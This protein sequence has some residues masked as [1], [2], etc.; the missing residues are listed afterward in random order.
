MSRPLDRSY[1]TPTPGPGTAHVLL[2]H[3]RYAVIDVIDLLLV[4]QHA[5]RIHPGGYAQT[6]RCGGVK[7]LHVVIGKSLWPDAQMIDHKDGDKLNCRR[8]NLRPCTRSQNAKNRCIERTNKSGFKG[9]RLDKGRWRA[10]IYADR[11]A[12]SLGC[13]DSPEQAA[14]AYDA[15]AIRLHGEFAR[16]NFPLQPQEAA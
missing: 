1:P 4:S 10:K 16:L 15:A 3:G 5:W 11:V 6:G 7:Q 12:H 8:S 2:G 9:V 13:H 14:R